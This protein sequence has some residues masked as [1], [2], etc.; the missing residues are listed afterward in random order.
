MVGKI[1]STYFD[2]GLTGVARALF[3]TSTLRQSGITFVGTLI[4]GVF[5]AVFY[6][7]TARALGP[8][9]FGLM[10]VVI[11]V[12]TLVATFSDFGVDTGLVRFVSGSLKKDKNRAYRF[13]KL[14]LKIK[15]VSGGVL[16]V[17]GV[18]L[19]DFI[20]VS[21]F[22]KP[23]LAPGLRVGF[24]AV[25]TYLLLGFVVNTLKS[26]QKFVLWGI[27]QVGA[28]FLRL[29]IIGGLFAFGLLTINLSIWTYSLTLLAGAFFGFI[30]FVPKNFLRIRGEGKVAREFLHYNKWIASFTII[31]AVSS[32]LDT[33]IAARLLTPSEIGFY[34]AANQLV[35]IVPQIVGA[36]GTVLAPKMAEMQGTSI[37]SYLKK[38]QVMVTA[39]A[40]LGIF[41]IPI[42]TFLVPFI[43]GAEY[44]AAIPLFIVLLFAML[45]FLLSV[46]VNNSILFYFSYPKLFFWLAI[47]HLCIIGSV[48]WVLI[49]AYG[50]LGAALTVLVGSIFNFVVPAVWVVRKLRRENL[51]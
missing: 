18:L 44:L 45:V 32:K 25:L 40:V 42:V 47:G 50:A 11:S 26:Y 23:E 16:T 28:N 15:L 48:G 20:A 34:S 33:F 3:A 24:T 2:S 35:Y 51:L 38:T 29:L 10:S 9:S 41:G 19:S 5:G 4:N 12:A 37:V 30:F 22:Q 46:P 21:V 49:S 14:S 39:L 43:F 6:M 27:V 17:I 1:K 31:A 7:L 8:A 36:L 13:L